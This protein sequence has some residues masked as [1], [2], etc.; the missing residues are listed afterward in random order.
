MGIWGIGD[1]GGIEICGRRHKGMWYK[2]LC[3]GCVWLISSWTGQLSAQI[4]WQTAIHLGP[5]LQI[6][7]AFP[8]IQQPSM[9]I[10]AGGFRRTLGKKAWH[11]KYGFPEVGIS[12]MYGSFGNPEILGWGI[13]ILPSLR[14]QLWERGR[15]KLH[16]RLGT[17]FFYVHKPYDRISNPNNN[18]IG[19]RLNSTSFFGLDASWPMGD[20]F[21]YVLGI[22]GTH[23]S[24]ARV[25]IP[26]L[27][28]NVP[29]LSMGI[30]YS[31]G[32][33]RSPTTKDTDTIRDSS[34]QIYPAIRL[35]Y[36]FSSRK[37]PD[38][39]LYPIYLASVSLN[40]FWR[41]KMRFKLGIEGFYNVGVAEFYRNHQ[42]DW[43]PMPSGAIGIAVYGGY[44]FVLGRLSLI[45]QLG[46]YIKRAE[47]MDYLLYTKLGVQYS[48]FDQQVRDRGQPFIGIYVHSHSG[49]ADFAE[50]G[51]GWQF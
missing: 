14:G 10:E 31:I 50:L 24:N 4:T 30:R 28:I 15:F 6:N 35:G 47:L 8:E 11:E 20:Q 51:I 48:L 23:I 49:E 22:S 17:S 9:L 46:P 34:F 41:N 37:I 44:E 5:T 38:G 33:E 26:N 40:T 29:A 13:S 1:I 39:P 18:A 7:D 36:G 16:Y 42:A 25:R 2:A 43:V 45:G 12:M 27:G 19:A 21:E 32:E 3:L